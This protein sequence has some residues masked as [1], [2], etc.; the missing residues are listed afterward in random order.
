MSEADIMSQARE[1]ASEFLVITKPVFVNGE[2]GIEYQI[3]MSDSALQRLANRSPGISELT[4]PYAD[5]PKH[6]S[7]K[8][9]D[10]MC[11]T[12]FQMTSQCPP[13]LYIPDPIGRNTGAPVSVAA[14]IPPLFPGTARPVRLN[15]P[16]VYGRYAQ[17]S[18]KGQVSEQRDS[19]QGPAA[20][21]TPKPQQRTRSHC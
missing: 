7:A 21:A 14:P 1:R 19:R 2:H 11:L 17:D 4:L 15:T 10:Q 5:N 9:N 18:R 20:R 8:M 12:F 6:I 3:N 16:M 13:K